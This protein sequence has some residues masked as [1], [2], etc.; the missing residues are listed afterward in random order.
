[1]QFRKNPQQKTHNTADTSI[2]AFQELKKTGQINRETIKAFAALEQYQ[3]ITRRALAEVTGIPVTNLCRV[4]HDAV[5]TA[6]PL[7]KICFTEKC[8]V[9][10]KRVQWFSLVDWERP[11]PP[12]MIQG[13]LL[14]DTAA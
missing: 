14:N 6:D 7:I 12:V 1:M 2:E 3:P 10:K 11:A 9:T 13:T 5:G 4:L 8:P